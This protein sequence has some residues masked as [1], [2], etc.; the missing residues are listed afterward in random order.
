MRDSSLSPVWR[1]RLAL[2]AVVLCAAGLP[3]PDALGAVRYGDVSV[4]AEAPP[5]EEAVHGYVEYAIT[6]TNHSADRSHSIGL[7]FP[8]Q[9]YGGGH[10]IRRV[11]RTVTVGPASTAR[12][13]LFQLPLPLRGE[14][15]EVVIDGRTQRERLDMTVGAGFSGLSGSDAGVVAYVSR[16]VDGAFENTA[17]RALGPAGSA[18]G[19]SHMPPELK[20]VRSELPVE[21]WSTSWLA[22]SSYD[23]VVVTGSELLEMPPDAKSALWRYVECG[24]T[25]L[26]LGAAPVPETWRSRRSTAAGLTTTCVGFGQCI[27]CAEGRVSDWDPQRWRQVNGAWWA[28]LEPFRTSRSIED[29]NDTFPVVKGLRTPVRGLMVLMLLFVIVIGPVNLLVLSRMKRRIWLLWTVPAISLLTCG[30]VTLYAAMAEGWSGRLRIAGLT[31]LDQTTHR[32][33][34]IG[35]AAFYSP[36][37]PRG[38][39][40]FG[41]ETELTPQVGQSGRYYSSWD[42]SGRARDV[43]W[44]NDQHLASG[45]VTARVPAHF[46]LRKSETRRE[47]LTVDRA[48]DGSLVIVN[49]LGAPIN[50]L[51]L[52]D[53]NGD[54]YFTSDIPAGAQVTL[55]GAERSVSASGS[56]DSLRRAFTQDWLRG[57]D[58]IDAHP[59]SLL[60]PGC[61][62]AALDDDAPFIEQGLRK[63]KYK[64]CQSV[65][66]GIL[67]TAPKGTGSADED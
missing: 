57:L 8:A 59:H 54:I 45:W 17:R 67:G 27:E 25:L 40:H 43:D 29:A 13:S 49:G 20:F 19:F 35:W 65:V 1:L 50:R 48:D 62:I 34:T 7:R 32:A 22:Y 15:I 61:Y 3:A 63:A 18:R 24:G 12:V 51:W 36:V 14:G 44:T 21:A 2:A 60:M 28:T 46:M 53:E 47:R 42:E 38:G 52:A 56:A 39:L 6:A 5:R 10:C 9:N 64:E 26:V 66:Y 55:P 31:I 37:T 11:T 58:A 33:T 4:S 23:G 30:A 41:Y 16:N